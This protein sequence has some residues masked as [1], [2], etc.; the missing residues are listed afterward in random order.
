[1]WHLGERLGASLSA[2]RLPRVRHFRS[3]AAVVHLALRLGRITFSA[4]RKRMEP[5]PPSSK[6]L[7]SSSEHV[8]RRFLLRGTFAFISSRTD[9]A[10]PRGTVMLVMTT[11]PR[12]RRPSSHLGTHCSSVG[13]SRA[14][15]RPREKPMSEQIRI[16]QSV[17]EGSGAYNQHAR[18]QTAAA[19][20]AG[21]FLERAARN[22]AIDKWR[23]A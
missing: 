12:R 5:L 13:G 7:L 8:W 11:K 17:M 3:R 18:H 2:L 19:W 9:A 15:L 6:R 4:K 10:P 20:A 23:G 21:Q 22:L 16:S 14:I 1:M